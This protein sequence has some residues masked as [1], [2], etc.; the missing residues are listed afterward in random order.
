MY[1]RQLKIVG[2]VCLLLMM[3]PNKATR[4]IKVEYYDKTRY[5]LFKCDLA[6]IKK[7]WGYKDD[8]YGFRLVN[9]KKL[10]H[11]GDDIADEPYV[12]S[13]QVSQVYYV[14][15]ERHPDWA[16]VVKTK[17]RK[18]FDLGQGEVN[19]DDDRNYHENEPFNLSINHDSTKL[20]MILS[21]VHIM[22]YLHLK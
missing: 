4:I 11:K 8:E 21:S 20:M 3:T 18:V 19:D 10:I 7:D 16:V 15:D 12:L 5:V 17:P 22:T 6:D 9:F 2:C 1:G 13:T 14:E